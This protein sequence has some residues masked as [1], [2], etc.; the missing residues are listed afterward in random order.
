MLPAEW[1]EE[2][3]SKN[4]NPEMQNLPDSVL[5]S[6]CQINN[7]RT[8][9]E[10]AFLGYNEALVETCQNIFTRRLFSLELQSYAVSNRNPRLQCRICQHP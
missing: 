9:Q 2:Q 7:L 3:Y 5:C 4:G 6:H 10:S 1:L 8:V